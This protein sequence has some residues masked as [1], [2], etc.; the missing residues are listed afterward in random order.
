MAGII[1]PIPAPIPMGRKKTVGTVKGRV[2]DAEDPRRPGL[3]NAI[4]TADGVA[5]LVRDERGVRIV[6]RIGTVEDVATELRQ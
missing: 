5:E 4:I 6:R 3:A 2:Y 1:R